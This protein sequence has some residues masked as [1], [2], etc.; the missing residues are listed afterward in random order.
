VRYRDAENI[1]TVIQRDP[2]GVERA[3]HTAAG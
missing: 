1:D 3:L 2:E